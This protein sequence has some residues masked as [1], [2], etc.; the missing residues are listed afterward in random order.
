MSKKTSYD[1]T[2]S[3]RSKINKYVKLLESE[4][5]KLKQQN[6]LMRETIDNLYR[7]NQGQINEYGRSS[8]LMFIGR[9]IEG[10][11]KKLD[12]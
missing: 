3:E 1:L 7:Y 5:Q 9:T 6:E 4:N 10:T 11:F 8:D 12:N 2:E